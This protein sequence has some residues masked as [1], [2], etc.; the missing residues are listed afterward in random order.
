MAST[1]TVTVNARD[2]VVA[3]RD[4]I[5]HRLQ[6]NE[7]WDQRPV[8]MDICAGV[9]CCPET[10]LKHHGR[11]LHTAGVRVQVPNRQKI[12][13]ATWELTK[14]RNQAMIQ[15]IKLLGVD[16][17]K[18]L[19]ISPFLIYFDS[20]PKVEQEYLINLMRI[21]LSTDA[22]L[23]C[24]S[25]GE[26]QLMLKTYGN[27]KPPASDVLEKLQHQRPTGSFKL[28]APPEV[29]DKLH[30]LDRMIGTFKQELPLFKQVFDYY[31]WDRT[32]PPSEAMQQFLP[33]GSWPRAEAEP[34]PEEP[35]TLELTD[36]E[37][38]RDDAR[39]DPTRFDFYKM[40]LH[41]RQVVEPTG[42]WHAHKYVAFVILTT[43]GQWVAVLDC[44]TKGN[45]AYLFLVGD[46]APT[47]PVN[48]ATG[49]SQQQPNWV[50][51]AV[52]T[53][54]QLVKEGL[55]KTFIRRFVHSPGWEERIT[56][57]LSK[58]L[59]MPSAAPQTP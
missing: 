47:A 54:H 29:L 23:A 14:R 43:G 49:D 24:L 6:V 33:P 9:K 37:V 35:Q 7:H 4:H 12:W 36:T 27:I 21:T 2:F 46:A 59:P 15:I 20:Q 13:Y 30:E 51:D 38:E 16:E 57:F 32:T 55:G 52:K 34:P 18:P 45:A 11:D 28:L 8:L 26:R 17:S 10:L 39:V 42:W 5:M 44:A 48:T 22:L 41:C 25:I 53:K 3:L 31:Y 58:P 1:K 56:K 40:Q 50:A 19:Q